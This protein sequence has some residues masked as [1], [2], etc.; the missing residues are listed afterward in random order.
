VTHVLGMTHELK[1]SRSFFWLRDGGKGHLWPLVA[2]LSV[3]PWD[4]GTAFPSL[5]TNSAFS[6]KECPKLSFALFS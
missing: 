1:L 2:L 4:L 3:V 5:G 6:L